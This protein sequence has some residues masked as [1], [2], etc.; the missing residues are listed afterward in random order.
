MNMEAPLRLAVLISGSGTNLQ[1]IIDGCQSGA[2]PAAVAL[3]ISSRE[4]AYGLVRARQAHIPTA[5]FRRKDFPDNAAA[6]THLL[7][8]LQTHRIDMIALAGYLKIVPPEIIRAFPRRIVNIHPGLL[9]GYGGKGMYGHYVHEAVIANRE[10]ESGVT[11]H[12]VDEQYDHGQIL[13]QEKV[14]VLPEDTPDTLAARVLVVEHRLYPRVI[15]ELCESIIKESRH[16]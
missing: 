11:V 9:P 10:K 4:E 3:V 14:R 6:V 5:I 1:A 7:G 8:L 12:L 15:R 13:A 16:E 2:I